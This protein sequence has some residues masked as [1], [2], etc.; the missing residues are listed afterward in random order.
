[1]TYL[2]DSI[3]ENSVA[4]YLREVAKDQLKIEQLRKG[5]DFLITDSDGNRT[6]LEV[7]SRFDGDESSIQRL[8]KL[9]VM[10]PD[11]NRFIL[12]TNEEPSP[13]RLSKFKEILSKQHDANWVSIKD[14]PKYL[15]H[16]SASTIGRESNNLLSFREQNAAPDTKNTIPEPPHRGHFPYLSNQLSPEAL[17]H[18]RGDVENADKHLR[19]GERIIQAT[20][21][22]ADIQNFSTLVNESP[23]ERLQLSMNRY[24]R[25]VRDSIFRHGGMLD[26]FIGDGVLA[27]FGYPIP[28]S[29]S[30]ANAVRFAQ[31]VISIGNDVLSEWTGELNSV[32]PTGIRVGVS[33]GD[34]W[35]I[36]I[37]STQIE[38][39]LL[40]DTINLAARLEKNCQPGKF[41]L[42]NVTLVKSAREDSGFI[43]TLNLSEKQLRPDQAKGQ[44]GTIKCWTLGDASQREDLHVKAQVTQIAPSKSVV[45]SADRKRKTKTSVTKSTAVKL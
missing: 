29:T 10:S 45:L 24:Y 26:K 3:L 2:L 27:V 36:N 37:G 42:D 1:M 21:V 23:P 28:D 12:A 15:N 32:I 20:V 44:R 31:D 19:L 4:D 5:P 17:R 9:L 30:A 18:L 35:P 39:N 8:E 34:I 41:L 38:I 40:G 22:L 43:G 25:L 7:K 16:D 11:A 6:V 13:G 33:T 14:L